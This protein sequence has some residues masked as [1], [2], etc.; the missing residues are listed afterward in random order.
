VVEIRGLIARV[1]LYNQRGDRGLPQQ[2]SAEARE[3]MSSSSTSHNYDM[4]CV[5]WDG[6]PLRDGTAGLPSTT[7][8]LGHCRDG[9]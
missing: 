6:P 4:V 3:P 9:L 2:V 5:P 7:D 8:I 1:R